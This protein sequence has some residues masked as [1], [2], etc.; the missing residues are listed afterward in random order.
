MKII[1]IFFFL[2][3]TLTVNCQTDSIPEFV[4][5]NTAFNI[6]EDLT[7]N[8]KYGMV[9]G[10]EANLKVHLIPLGYSYAYHFKSKI[11]TTGLAGKFATVY[12]VYESYVDVESKLPIKAIRNVIENNYTAYNEA[13]FD[14]TN[15]RIIS[16]KSGYLNDLPD[17]TM[18]IIAL[19]YYA[20]NALYK[21]GQEKGVIP[22]Y[23][24]F[25]EEIY[26]LEIHYI[27]NEKIKTNFGKIETMLYAPIAGKG[28]VF[29][30]E[31]EL[32]IW[33]SNDENYL[34]IK[35]WAKLPFGSL[36]IELHEY[37]GLRN[38]LLTLKSLKKDKKRL[39]R[40]RK[41]KGKNENQ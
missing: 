14:R 7:Y 6:G 26:P 30:N 2:T 35:I 28:D 39:K 22:M 37:S 1:F 16:S 4:I 8:L 25:D 15:K 40:S 24:Y 18:D 32:K 10:G 31:N 36:K 34:P 41:K 3:L 23:L 13:L 27:K 5:P 29:A 17:N 20:R 12:D 38:K 19:F 11:V 9:K 33:I 21:F